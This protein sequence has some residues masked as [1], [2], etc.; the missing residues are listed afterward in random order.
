MTWGFLYPPGKF[1]GAG[2]AVPPAS[3]R[4]HSYWRHPE[5]FQW[6]DDDECAGD[7]GHALGRSLISA[8]GR[9]L[10]EACFKYETPFW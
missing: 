8:R 5:K 1:G 3:L 9:R 6:E 7:V 2:A 4:L 10:F